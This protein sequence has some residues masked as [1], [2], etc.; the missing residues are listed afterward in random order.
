MSIEDF[1]CIRHSSLCSF[2]IGPTMV[3]QEKKFQIKALRWL[4]NGIL[5]LIFANSIAS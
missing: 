3:G 4:E 2:V 5:K 1:Q